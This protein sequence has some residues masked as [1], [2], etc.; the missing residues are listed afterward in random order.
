[1]ALKSRLATTT[2]DADVDVSSLSLRREGL[3]PLVVLAVQPPKRHLCSSNLVEM[4]VR[5]LDEARDDA[6]IAPASNV[7]DDD[8]VSRVSPQEILHHGFGIVWCEGCLRHRS[9][10]HFPVQR[11]LLK[12]QVAETN[13]SENTNVYSVACVCVFGTRVYYWT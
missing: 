8:P 2:V 5:L 12:P 11:F 13:G 9:A 6:S 7:T 4:V 1:M 3:G 10:L